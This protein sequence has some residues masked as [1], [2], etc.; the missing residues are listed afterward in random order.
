MF[1]CKAYHI[2]IGI[3]VDGEIVRD[4]GTFICWLPVPQ[5]Q[6]IGFGV[7]IDAQFHGLF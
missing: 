6:R 5:G 1:Q 2:A 4:I 3:E 7:V